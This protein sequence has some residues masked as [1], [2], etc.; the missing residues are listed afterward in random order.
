MNQVRLNR[1]GDKV[2]V[3][4]LRQGRPGKT[5]A[6]LGGQ[7]VSSDRAKRFK[8]MNRLGAVLSKR[9]EDFPVVFQHDSP[10]FPEQCG[11]PIVD[12]RG[13]V[14]GINIARNGRASTMAIPSNHLATIIDDL[15]RETVARR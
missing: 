13:R 9:S 1:K 15:L 10:L 8:M 5:T 6:T 3:E 14:L 4:Y 7:T 11:G 12:L 2:S